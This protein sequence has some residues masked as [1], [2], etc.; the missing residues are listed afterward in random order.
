MQRVK[1]ICLAV[2]VAAMPSAVAV[3]Q[4]FVENVS[5]VGTT[6]APFLEIE[7]GARALGMGGAFTA[8]ADDIS[9]IY[10]N[11]A[12]LA[13]VNQGQAGFVH[14]RWIADV[15]FDHVSTVIPVTPDMRLGAFVSTVT[16][17]EMKV[18]TVQY[19]EGTGELFRASDLAFGLSFATRLTDRLTFGANGKYIYQKIWHMS[20]SSVAADLGLLF[21]T[22]FH[23]VRLGMSISNFGPDMQ[24]TGR[25]TKIYYDTDPT[26][27]G[28]NERIPANLETEQWP[29]PLLF[30]VGLAGEV[31]RNRYGALTLAAD[32]VHPN[33]NH[34]YV[35]LG[36]EFSYR[37][38]AFLRA[39]WKTL[40][41]ADS[42]QGL[43]AGVGV[44]YR[45]N[46]N[47]GFIADVAY[48][49]FGR[50]ENVMRYSLGILF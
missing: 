40:F 48:A 26:N 24:M 7:V 21:R 33:D 13:K 43:T 18:R 22:P 9:A 28:N 19:P 50:L 29:L 45:L 49:D 4:T 11:P 20:A 32:A 46:G 8:T 1:R 10:W 6:A 35:N 15:N 39:G 42:E 14:T 3:G 12:G 5:K 41:L 47:V 2:L 34:E 31:V 27:P 37:D 16:M 30:R 36:A 25:D 17:D 38:W 44:K 23:D